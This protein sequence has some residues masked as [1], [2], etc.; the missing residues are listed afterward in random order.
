MIDASSNTEGRSETSICTIQEMKCKRNERVPLKGILKTEK[1]K[2]DE[3]KIAE[4]N[5]LQI[6][7]EKHRILMESNTE[8]DRRVERLE[9]ELND[10]TIQHK[11]GI[12]WLRMQLDTT[13]HDLNIANGR[14]DELQREL[15][16]LSSDQPARE[17]SLDPTISESVGNGEETENLISRLE[18]RIKKYE[19][20]FGIMENQ[21]AMIKSSSGE[22]IKTLKEEIA[23]LMEDRTRAE[24][25]LLNQL[26]ELD[27]EN[28]R[29]Q[30]EHALEIH[31]KN[32]TIEI[33][34]HLESC[35]TSAKEQQASSL[36][37]L[38]YDGSSSTED[39][40]GSLLGC[41]VPSSGLAKSSMLYSMGEEKAEL[42][43][44]LD[45]A[46]RKLE[47]FRSG[48]INEK[49]EEL[50]LGM[51]MTV[52]SGMVHEKLEELKSE[53]K[54]KADAEFVD[55][56][57]DDTELE[58]KMSDD[59]ESVQ[60]TSEEK[61]ALNLSIDKVKTVLG[62]AD[63]AVSKVKNMIKNLKTKDDP[64]AKK[65]RKRMF[66]V[67]ESATLIHEEVKL[68]V[69]LI[70]L[71]LRNEFECLKKNGLD[72]DG[73]NETKLDIHELIND[74]EQIQ[75]DA[76]IQ[77]RKAGAQ[78]SRQIKDLEKR[79][80]SGKPN[81]D[82]LL[83]KNSEKCKK[84]H[85]SKS[86]KKSDTPVVDELISSCKANRDSKIASQVEGGGLTINRDVMYSLEKELVQFNERL[87]TK[88]QKI[89]SL[90]EQIEKHKIRENNLRKELRSSIKFNVDLNH[91]RTKTSKD[92]SSK[93]I[94]L[95]S[96][97]A[98]FHQSI[99]REIHTRIDIGPITPIGA[100]G[101]SLLSDQTLFNMK[102][103]GEDG[104]RKKGMSDDS[105]EGGTNPIT[106]MHAITSDDR[107]DSIGFV[108]S[109]PLACEKQMSNLPSET[110]LSNGE[111]RRLQPTS[112][113]IK[114]LVFLPP[115]FFSELPK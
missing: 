77:L 22:V 114:K 40:K 37:T 8:K 66:S 7:R 46:N 30:L 74:M 80:A 52:D 2:T 81:L 16:L 87:L 12:Y 47:N 35:S 73:K 62:S 15:R 79:A 51:N 58:L 61:I 6:Y 106:Q 24:L 84:K 19:T 93:S 102:F 21:I 39:T 105:Q 55:E 31:N 70:E 69:L 85:S 78:F 63:D 59:I 75:N 82:H 18:S 50:Q 103:K 96:K 45:E 76:F 33:L 28:R 107:H 113:E 56:N 44:K 101:R 90:K 23:T 32:E 97:D 13:R 4:Q 94:E 26:T 48:M 54:E 42:Q 3:E 95:F 17:V 112:R 108:P 14:I 64:E 91:G 115:C 72:N 25:D 68:S 111:N 34:R 99:P 98:M 65:E 11:E 89:V 9:K 83:N 110:E 100:S 27:N 10:H 92:I 49:L 53:I 29:K 5:V 71:K 20:S 109:P 60:Q 43:R 67:L 86:S 38:L 57:L 104:R 36:R 41:E 1:G 88:N